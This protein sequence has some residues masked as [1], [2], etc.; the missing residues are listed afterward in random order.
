MGCRSSAA[1]FLCYLTELPTGASSLSI[2]YRLSYFPRLLTKVLGPF[3]FIN[4]VLTSEDY[5]S[6]SGKDLM[7]C[8]KI[9][10]I[11]CF[12]NYEIML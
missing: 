2:F 7:L 4:G 5:N 11:H 1:L 10:M 8:F 12:L 9:W 6:V 3:V